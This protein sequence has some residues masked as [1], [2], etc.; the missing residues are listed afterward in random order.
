L[1]KYFGRPISVWLLARHFDISPLTA[2]GGKPKGSG[3]GK[4][5]LT[6]ASKILNRSKDHVRKLLAAA[7][8]SGLIRNYLQ[9]GDQI[10]VFYTS[11][12][13][14]IALTDI[15]KLGPI[16]AIKIKDLA[17]IHIIP[18]EVE[19][20][21]L[22]RASFHRQRQEE[23]RQI[24]AEGSDLQQP[25]QLIEPTTLLHTCEQPA[26]V[27]GRSD[28]FIY[29]EPGFR[30]Y[31]G[32]IEAIAQSRGLSPATVSRHLSNSYRLVASPVRAFREE[33][34]PLVKKQVM[35]RLPLPKNIPAK[36]CRE[37][38]LVSL[39]GEWWEPHCNVYVL[40]HRLVSARRR[41]SRIQ[42]AIDKRALCVK[43]DAAGDLEKI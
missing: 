8:Q 18:T 31:G 37:D 19:A 17:N 21:H 42:T 5:T 43:I 32:S 23:I 4:F 34:P 11:L 35:E 12:E 10:K 33:L 40:N 2:P 38:G 6:E 20:Q 13:K 14:V 29:V 7:K 24:K 3:I 41:R 22:Q 25:T 15:E 16:A 28:R 26:R 9:Q 27:L 30:F 39:F 1:F 36:L